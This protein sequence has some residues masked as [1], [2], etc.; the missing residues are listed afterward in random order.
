[1]FYCGLV[2]GESFLLTL[3][4]ER[5]SVNGSYLG[6]M[7]HDESEFTLPIAG[8]YVHNIPVVCSPVPVT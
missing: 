3:S 4:S 5:C 8:T 1:M 7:E 6:T 2:G